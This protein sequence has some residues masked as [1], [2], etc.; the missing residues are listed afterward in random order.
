LRGAVPSTQKLVRERR[1]PHSIQRNAARF[2][3]A[4]DESNAPFKRLEQPALV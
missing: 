3:E 4:V 2:V 1:L